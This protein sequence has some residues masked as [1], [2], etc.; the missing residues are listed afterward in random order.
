VPASA[1]A[2]GTGRRFVADVLSRWGLPDPL[3]DLAVLVTSELV[4]NAVNH[5]PPPGYLQV[6]ADDRRIRIEVSD[7]SRREPRMVRPGDAVT[8]GR[9]LLL[10]DRLASRWGWDPEP[11]GKVVWCEV[12][13]PAPS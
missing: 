5:A 4:A 2:C 8:G 10:I 6:R 13:L 1:S 9:G 7:S 11:P 12:N 3:V